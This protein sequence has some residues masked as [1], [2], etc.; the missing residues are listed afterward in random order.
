MQA[1]ENK[2]SM[3][4]NLYDYVGIASSG[5]CFLHCTLLPVVLVAM[6]A[7]E[8][9]YPFFD[10]LFLGVSFVAV[11]FSVRH[12]Q[13]TLLKK[14][15]WGFFGLLAVS[16]LMEEVSPVF[17]YLGYV[18]ALGLISAHVYNI[19][20]CRT[21]AVAPSQKPKPAMAEKI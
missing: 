1:V 13:G 11:Y 5:L 6:K 9:E 15:L 17:E 14:M 10:F 18:A 8:T 3:K 12:H 19:R 20:Y 4:G 16:I 7:G 2:N 21:C